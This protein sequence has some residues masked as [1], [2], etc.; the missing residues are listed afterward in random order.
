MTTLLDLSASEEEAKRR[1]ANLDKMMAPQAA[2]QA[3][4][5]IGESAKINPAQAVE[6]QALADQFGTTP[7]II[8]AY[9]DDFRRK[10]L[11]NL[12]AGTMQNTP[13][14]AKFITDNPSRGAVM[15]STLD[16]TAAT[17]QATQRRL[18]ES[19]WSGV[20]PQDD[21]EFNLANTLI[22][23]SNMLG[24]IVAPAVEGVEHYAP[25]YGTRVANV[26]DKAAYAA[27]AALGSVSVL[28]VDAVRGN[29][30]FGEWYNRSFVQPYATR[31]DRREEE[32]QG[33]SFGEK[34]VSTAGDLTGMLGLIYS[35]GA[36]GV[37]PL[38]AEATVAAPA[39]NITN[40]LAH[41]TAAAAP[42]DL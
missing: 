12:T 2:E 36:S 37:S 11:A 15:H 32:A 1:Q 3:G 22:R 27:A 42:E 25:I 10:A 26:A 14:L 34:L 18:H 33:Y 24:G 23:V 38:F 13:E 21:G 6:H 41:G 29:T 39:L 9:P 8:S 19:R 35:S 31:I 30:E 7:D 4:A 5:I 17:E 28:P 16:N 40:M 20:K